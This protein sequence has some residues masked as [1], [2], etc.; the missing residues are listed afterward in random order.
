VRWSWIAVGAVTTSAGAALLARWALF[1][2]RIDGVSMEPAFR[3]GDAVLALRASVGAAVKRGD[4]VVCRLPVELQGPTGF[5]VKR[6]TATAGTRVD[7]SEVVPDGQI[8]VQG[9]GVRS[10]DSRA[11]GPLPLAAVRGRV[12]ARLSLP[13][14]LAASIEE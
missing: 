9:D 1:V 5:L 2:V 3:S 12:I 6:V 10:Y 11:F 4:V 8:F 13:V 14:R 7:G